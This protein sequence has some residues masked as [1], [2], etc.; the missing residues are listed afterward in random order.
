VALIP[1]SELLGYGPTVRFPNLPRIH[2]RSGSQLVIYF[3]NKSARIAAEIRLAGNCPL[4]CHVKYATASAINLAILLTGMGLGVMLAP[5]VTRTAKAGPVAEMQS[6]AGQNPVLTPP[7][8]AVPTGTKTT[9]VQPTMTVGTAGIYLILTH[10]VQSDEMVVNGVDLLKL[11][12]EELNLLSRFVSAQE[13]NNAI[14][15]SQAGELFQVGN[16]TFPLP[17]PTQVPK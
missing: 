9:P 7:K 14:V 12:Q 13:I 10:H 2:A 8:P 4:E 11:H 1:Q 17:A 15:R 3:L 5:H 6:A 16:P